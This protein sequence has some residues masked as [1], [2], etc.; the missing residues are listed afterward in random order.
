MPL[1]RSP[2]V[3]AQAS[4]FDPDLQPKKMTLEQAQ[5][6]LDQIAS[7]LPSALVHD[8]EGAYSSDEIEDC[9]AVLRE[10][11]DQLTSEQ[12]ES[13]IRMVRQHHADKVEFGAAFDMG[14]EI[15]QQLTLARAMRAR[16][17][18]ENGKL[19]QRFSAKE[20]KE[21]TSA[22]TSLI[23][24]LTRTMKEVLNFQRLLKIEN[25]VKAAVA[26][27]PEDAQEEFLSELKRQLEAGT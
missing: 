17:L 1:Q 15:G 7:D 27:M 9:I 12:A 11:A 8:G 16:L 26:T 13:I 22:S 19:S 24:V 2:S 18:D 20:A 10:C 6:M 3:A 14:E 5:E 4:A 23:N 21:V 25:A